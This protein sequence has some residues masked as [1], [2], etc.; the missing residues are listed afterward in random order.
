MA[1][2]TRDDQHPL[3]DGRPSEAGPGADGLRTDD[4]E[5]PEAVA[6][7]PSPAE[8]DPLGELASLLELVRSAPRR[9]DFYWLLRAIDRARYADD[10]KAKRLGEALN[11]RQDPVRMGQSPHLAFSTATIDTHEPAVGERPDR[12]RIRNF[13]LLGPNGP[14]PLFFTEHVCYQVHKGDR[15]W[16]AFLD[17]IQHRLIT[18]FYRAW[19]MHQPTIQQDRPE[20]DRLL[21]YI[22]CLAGLGLTSLRE[23]DDIPDSAKAYFAGRLVTSVCSAESLESVLRA[24]FEVPTIVISFR[25]EWI[26]IPPSSFLKL[27]ESSETGA[28]GQSTVIGERIWTVQQRFRVR[29][30]PMPLADYE[31]MLPR[32]GGVSFAR[33]RSWVRLMAGMGM[34]WDLQLVLRKEDGATTRLGG[35]SQLGWTSWV[36]AGPA[37]EDLDDL[38]LEPEEWPD[39]RSAA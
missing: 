5:G 3:S 15:A 11:T 38:V 21:H 18:L 32:E 25:G 8:P 1:D 17:L 6:L 30:G 23:R 27:G 26:D 19:A 14:M 10:P 31:R 24:Y 7:E 28:L 35:G 37:L 22:L 12:L 33:L 16:R 29:M 2:P 34:N 4:Q 13:G 20:T 9:Y 39:G 36:R